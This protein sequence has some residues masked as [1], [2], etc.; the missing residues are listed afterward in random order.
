MDE[1]KL[2]FVQWLGEHNPSVLRDRVQAELEEDGFEVIWTP[3][4]LLEVQPIELFWAGGKNYAADQFINKRSMKDTV[5]DLRDGWYGNQYFNSAATVDGMIVEGPRLL[6]GRYG[7]LKKPV[8]CAG[9]VRKAIREANVIIGYTPGI[10]GTIEAGVVI[11]AD[12]VDLVPTALDVVIDMTIGDDMDGN[13]EG[14][15]NFE[16]QVGDNFFPLTDPPPDG[17]VRAPTD[18]TGENIVIPALQAPVGYDAERVAAPGL[19]LLAQITMN[20]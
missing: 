6:R 20:L 8:N 14:G 17:T 19:D 12:F 15:A 2:S 9:L 18:T 16:D 10:Q 11:G 7:I 4:Y 13:M 5:N 1:L 3:P